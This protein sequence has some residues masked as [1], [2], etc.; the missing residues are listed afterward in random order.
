MLGRLSVRARRTMRDR[1]VPPGRAGILVVTLHLGELLER[2]FLR[3]RFEGC[4]TDP[5]SR[6]ARAGRLPLAG[7]V[8]T[9]AHENLPVLSPRS[10]DDA[11]GSRL[12]ECS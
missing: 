5:A 1:M 7:D 4:C 2:W 3:Q 8:L 11:R 9:Y 6:S 10:R 12:L